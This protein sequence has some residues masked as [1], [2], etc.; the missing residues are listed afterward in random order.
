MLGDIDVIVVDR[1]GNDM[2]CTIP[3]KSVSYYRGYID[4]S[5]KGKDRVY[6]MVYLVGSPNALKIVSTYNSFKE[7]MG[8]KTLNVTGMSNEKIEKLKDYIEELREN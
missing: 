2:E 6:T 3:R 1:N 4:N 5:E 8:A 7:K